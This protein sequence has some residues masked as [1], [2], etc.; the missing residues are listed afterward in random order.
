MQ[1]DIFDESLCIVV[2][3]P[4]MGAGSPVVMPSDSV[5]EG[6]RQPQAS[7]SQIVAS[8]RFFQSSTNET[9]VTP[10]LLST[11]AT[12]A[13]L[14]EP[15]LVGRCFLRMCLWVEL[16]TCW[17]RKG[18]ARHRWR[19]NVRQLLTESLEPSAPAP[20]KA[21]RKVRRSSLWALRAMPRLRRN[22]QYSA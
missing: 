21:R 1:T 6:E 17:T 14:G 9:G 11:T 12:I 2:S 18:Q 7:T 16:A 10:H 3:C 15:D 22:K 8:P 19:P 20:V 5:S 4:E 13:D